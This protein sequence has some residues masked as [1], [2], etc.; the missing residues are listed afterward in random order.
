METSSRSAA[1]ALLYRAVSVVILMA[2][3]LYFTGSLGESSAIS[4]T[5]AIAATFAYYVHERLWD[6]ISWGRSEPKS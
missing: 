6:N 3:S 2:V 1:K 4:V 5:F